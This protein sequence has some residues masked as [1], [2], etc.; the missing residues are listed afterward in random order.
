[1]GALFIFIFLALVFPVNARVEL[2]DLKAK[3]W[4]GQ[5]KI[6]L[7]QA[8]KFQAVLPPSSLW[9]SGWFTVYLVDRHLVSHHKPQNNRDS[10]RSLG[11][12]FQCIHMSRYLDNLTLSICLLNSPGL[13]ITAYVRLESG[14]PYVLKQ[15]VEKKPVFLLAHQHG[16]HPGFWDPFSFSVTHRQIL[17]EQLLLKTPWACVKPT[18]ICQELGVVQP[19]SKP[20]SQQVGCEALP[21]CWT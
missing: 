19:R 18:H 20:T 15:R 3:W 10:K 9:W 6:C 11:K 21:L 14:C 5:Y 7:S 12:L 17:S 1:M 13:A 16:R 2:I 4:E 8:R